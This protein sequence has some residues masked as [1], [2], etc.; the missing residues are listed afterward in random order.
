M[1]D[2]LFFTIPNF[3][4][5][6]KISNY[7]SIIKNTNIQWFKYPITVSYAAGNFPFQIWNG[8]Y[9]SCYTKGAFYSD[10]QTHFNK[11]FVNLRFSFN[12]CK[13]TPN[14]YYDTMG[15]NILKIFDCGSHVI[16]IADF[17]FLNYLKNN[18]P[19]YEY[20]C[21]KNIDL[22]SPMTIES[23]NELINSGIFLLIGIPDKYSNNLDFLSSIDNKAKIEITINP[24][25]PQTCKNYELCRLSE[26]TTQ[27]N[28]SA[29]SIA[30]C[31]TR[32][33]LFDR[34]HQCISIEEIIE[35]YLPLGIKNFIFDDFPFAYSNNSI[36]Y[37]QFL[38]KYF[39][40]DEYQ[41]E[42]I[43]NYLKWEKNNG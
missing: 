4:Y 34:V 2:S 21:S 40:K 39:I 25:C 36:L 14:D 41:D 19:N 13:L 28:Y 37:L 35:K 9:N 16:E 30:N 17:D 11:N 8:N 26:Q 1:K 10:F 38:I 27:L 6:G 7:F 29:Q 33:N 24:R 31:Q 5:N 23:I 18:F 12:N 43:E 42:C 20:I 32:Y 3:F 22:Y 15:N